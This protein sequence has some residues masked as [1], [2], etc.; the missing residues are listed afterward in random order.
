MS[1]MALGRIRSVRALFPQHA[2]EAY[3]RSRCIDRLRVACGWPV[4][5]AV[6]GGTQVRAALQ[7]LPAESGA[8]VLEVAARQLTAAARIARNAASAL[9]DQLTP[10]RVPV[11]CPFPDIADHVVQAIAIRRK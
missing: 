5:L 7:N 11:R 9:A 2:P 1:R 3:V 4:A 8:G 10:V 6:I